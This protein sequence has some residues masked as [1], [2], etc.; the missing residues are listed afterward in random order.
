MAMI[1]L[2][3]LTKTFDHFAETNEGRNTLLE[4]RVAIEK[5]R[6]GAPKGVALNDHEFLMV[7]Q[8]LVAQMKP[9]HLRPERASGELTEDQLDQVAGGVTTSSTLFQARTVTRLGTTRRIGNLGITIE[10]EI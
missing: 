4:F 6:A 5:L 9:E 2:S 8:K 1:D 10:S 7:L 3:K